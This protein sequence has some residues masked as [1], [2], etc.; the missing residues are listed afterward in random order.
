MADDLSRLVDQL[1]SAVASEGE[2]D[3]ERLVEIADAISEYADQ[4][5]VPST[6]LDRARTRTRAP[7]AE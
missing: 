4:P 3:F 2:R 5:A 7:A 1:R 6:R